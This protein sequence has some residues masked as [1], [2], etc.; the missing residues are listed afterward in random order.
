M[1]QHMLQCWLGRGQQLQC[2][3]T[4]TQTQQATCCDRHSRGAMALHQEAGRT[5]SA[6]DDVQAVP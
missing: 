4:G 6:A 3:S 5:G 2:I 1:H